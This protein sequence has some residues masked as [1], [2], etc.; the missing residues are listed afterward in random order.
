MCPGIL[1]MFS[2]QKECYDELCVCTVLTSTVAAGEM[3]G[4][5]RKS[6]K[7][8]KKGAKHNKLNNNS[9]SVKYIYNCNTDVNCFVGI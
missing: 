1:M 2:E 3:G 7:V 5:N 9:R 6:S 8:R 4:E